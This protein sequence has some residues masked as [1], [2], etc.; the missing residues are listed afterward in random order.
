MVRVLIRRIASDPALRAALR[1]Q[2]ALP[3]HPFSD[4]SLAFDPSVFL[5][6]AYLYGADA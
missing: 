2:A 4:H 3:T 6:P 1:R 5:H